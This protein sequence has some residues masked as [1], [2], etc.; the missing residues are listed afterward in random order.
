MQFKLVSWNVRGLSDRDK[1]RL[2]QRLVVD[3]KAE[4][5]CFQETKLEGEMANLVKQ[6]CGGGEDGSNLP[7]LKQVALEEVL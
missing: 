2:V 3:W 6:I 4:I 1:R 5:V 7:T